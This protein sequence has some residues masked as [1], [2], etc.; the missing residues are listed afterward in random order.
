[1]KSMKVYCP[2]GITRALG[3]VENGEAKHIEAATVTAN[4]NGSGLTP[5]PMAHWRAI[6]AIRTAV[7]VLLMKMVITEVAKYTAAKATYGP[8]DPKVLTMKS[9]IIPEAPVFSRA[10]DIG[11]M[12]AKSTIVCQLIVL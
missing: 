2:A 6:G 12:A 9:A 3:G 10:V 11:S 5:I 8:L 7:T 4:R 1:M